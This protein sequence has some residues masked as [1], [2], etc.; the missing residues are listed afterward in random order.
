MECSRAGIPKAYAALAAPLGV[1]VEVTISVPLPRVTPSPLPHQPI[2][3]PKVVHPRPSEK[4]GEVDPIAADALPFP[5]RKGG[6]GQSGAPHRMRMRF[7]QAAPEVESSCRIRRLVGSAPARS[8]VSPPLLPLPL[9]PRGGS[10]SGGTMFSS[11]GSS[12]LCEYRPPPSWLSP[13]RHPAHLLEEAG[14]SGGPRGSWRCGGRFSI[15]A[16]APWWF[17]PVG[18]SGHRP[19]ILGRR[20]AT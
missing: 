16:P 20:V 17:L 4:P 7:S 19:L 8:P 18:G 1:R 15:S 14:G 12:G 6:G 11:T 9:V 13:T 10:G 5:S 3:F 2:P